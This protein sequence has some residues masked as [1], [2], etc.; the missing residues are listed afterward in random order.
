MSLV[1]TQLKLA[2]WVLLSAD[3]QNL[4]MKKKVY[5]QVCTNYLRIEQLPINREDID[6]VV[7]RI[8]WLYEAL[9]VVSKQNQKRQGSNNNNHQR[10]SIFEGI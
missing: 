2:K 1:G 5:V 3:E 7:N 9:G 6:L 4:F 10:Y 8:A